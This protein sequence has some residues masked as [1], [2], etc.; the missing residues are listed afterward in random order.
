MT[1][2]EAD[3]VTIRELVATAPPLT[4]EQRT[5]LAVLLK[6]NGTK[7]TTKTEGRAA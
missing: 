2:S 5:A 3:R 6:P 4:E 7:T 1:L